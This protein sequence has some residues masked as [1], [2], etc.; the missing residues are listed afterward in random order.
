MTAVRQP[1]RTA[2][3][4]VFLVVVID[5]L[6]FGLVLP[7]LPLFASSFIRH[8]GLS[9]VAGGALT[10]LLMAVFS[11]MQFVFAHLWGRVS[12]LIGRRPV[13]LVGLAGSVVFYTLFGYASGLSGESA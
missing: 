5:L 4:I 6:G 8:P 13:L 11:L 7:L 1:P 10:G 2:L 9:P 3:F 12:D